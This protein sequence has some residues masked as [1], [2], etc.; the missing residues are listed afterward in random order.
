MLRSLVGSEMCIRDRDEVLLKRETPGKPGVSLGVRRGGQS[1]ALSTVQT[2]SL[3][4]I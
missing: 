1:K 3:I 2:L 4:H